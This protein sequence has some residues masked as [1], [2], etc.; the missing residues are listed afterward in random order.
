MQLG[1]SE[2]YDAGSAIYL[3][4]GFSTNSAEIWV[5]RHLGLQNI[6]AAIQTYWNNFQPCLW[7]DV[8][9]SITCETGHFYSDGKRV[10]DKAELARISAIRIP[11]AYTDVTICPAS[12]SKIRAWGYDAK[13]RKQIMY[14]KAHVDSRRIQKYADLENF[15]LVYKR[16]LLAVRS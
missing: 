15:D 12:S 11:P 14:T 8:V 16:N 13:S 1:Y 10:S 4:V 5:L 7:Y 2:R 9:D 6:N 3:A